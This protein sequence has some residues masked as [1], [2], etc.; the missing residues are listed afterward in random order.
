MDD[1]A[2]W[3]DEELRQCLDGHIEPAPPL[4]HTVL[5]EMMRRYRMRVVAE[6]YA[7]VARSA[8]EW[9]ALT[10][11][12]DEYGNRTAS[13]IPDPSYCHGAADALEG[14]A[15]ALKPEGDGNDE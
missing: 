6:F 3:T 12:E 4:V 9:R 5:T 11:C 13:A 14:I 10:Y 15:E 8:Y 7:L 2:K 1:V